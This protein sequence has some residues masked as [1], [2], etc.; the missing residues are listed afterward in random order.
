ML[1]AAETQQPLAVLGDGCGSAYLPSTPGRGL[2][3]SVWA[4]SWGQLV[5]AGGRL[6]DWTDRLTASFLLLSRLGSPV[7][8]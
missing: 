4:L 6:A 7:T 8:P 3:P 2:F 1:S 5:G